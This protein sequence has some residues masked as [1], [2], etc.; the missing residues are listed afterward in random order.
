M[1]Q[2]K[3]KQAFYF[4][5]IRRISFIMTNDQLTNELFTEFKFEGF[6][7]IKP[8][9]CDSE[10]LLNYLHF[11]EWDVEVKSYFQPDM[12]LS[13]E[14]ARIEIKVKVDMW[15][16][17]CNGDVYLIHLKNSTERNPINHADVESDCKQFCAKS[18]LEFQAIDITLP[19][20]EP[21]KSNVNLLYNYAMRE[22]HLGHLWLINRFFSDEPSP[23]IGKLKK[24]LAR[25]GYETD[26]IYTFLFH[27]AVE[28][29]VVY[30]TVSDR[31]P[32]I[33]GNLFDMPVKQIMVVNDLK[34]LNPTRLDL[35]I[36]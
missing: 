30:F 29:E 14:Y 24:M 1:K 32:L 36:F 17:L 6:K 28:A 16:N 3:A 4:K 11:L 9:N 27:H 19:E 8:I 20:F 22:V 31:T 7:N 34:E 26:L 15:V 25:Y 33:K 18:K 35:E 12:Y 23:T 10:W 5:I 2:G 13:S 21:R